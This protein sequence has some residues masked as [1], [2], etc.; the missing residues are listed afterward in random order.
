MNYD[1]PLI[2]P[3]TIA[4]AYDMV[5]IAPAAFESTLQPLIDFKN[6]KGIETIFKSMESILTEFTGSD[7]PEQ[8]KYFIKYAYDTWGISY[9]LLVG[10]LKSHINAKDKDT[11]SAG[12]KAWWVPVRYVSM[13]Q[14]DDEGCLSDLYYGCLY[15]ATGAFDSWDSNSDGVYAA[16]GFFPYKKDTIDMYA[17]VY[18]GRLACANVNEVNTGP[19]RS[20]EKLYL[21]VS[22]ETLPASSVAATWTKCDPGTRAAILI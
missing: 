11:I 5:V 3:T 4:T 10:G 1:T 20:I 16:W 15:N 6:S 9:A 18:V 2:Q 13:P 21:K 22:Q 19:V 14:G 8:V 12:W 17:E 7:Q